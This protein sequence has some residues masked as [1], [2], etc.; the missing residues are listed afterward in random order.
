MEVLSKDTLDRQYSI[1]LVL[2]PKAASLIGLVAIFLL[3]W[4]S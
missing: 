3:D 2:D 1:V 4:H